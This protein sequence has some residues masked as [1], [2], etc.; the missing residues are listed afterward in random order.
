MRVYIAGPYTKGDVVVNIQ[1]AIEAAEIIREL[2]HIPYVP[3]LSH[4]WH[5]A[6]PHPWEYWM[7]LDMEWL[8]ACDAIIRLPGK[9]IG[10]DM[11]LEEAQKQGI[12]VYYIDM[13]ARRIEK[14]Y[15]LT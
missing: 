14:E 2:G 6:S 13:A 3:H 12:P 11:E 5:L 8:R 15:R 4:L 10:A 7:A 9:S 1:R